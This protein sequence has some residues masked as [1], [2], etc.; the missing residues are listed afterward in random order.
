MRTTGANMPIMMARIT[1][2]RDEPSTA[3][4]ARAIIKPGSAI[5][6][7]TRRWKERSTRS[8][9]PPAQVV[10]IATTKPTVIPINT[11]PNPTYREIRAP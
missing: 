6:A 8:T 11:A 3:T 7:S 1:F 10:G 2:C 5:M 4:M 9:R